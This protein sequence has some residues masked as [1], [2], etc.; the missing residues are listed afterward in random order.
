MADFSTFCSNFEQNRPNR[1]K[2][3]RKDKS[4]TVDDVEYEKPL[5]IKKSLAPTDPHNTFKTRFQKKLMT[6][7]FE[8]NILYY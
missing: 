3:K 8:K 5:H 1:S 7:F 2:T 6:F 4:F